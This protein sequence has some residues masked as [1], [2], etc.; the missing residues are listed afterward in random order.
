MAAAALTAFLMVLSATSCEKTG[1]KETGTDL[2]LEKT[3]V[4]AG[5]AGADFT[6]GYTMSGSHSENTVCAETQEDWIQDLKAEKSSISFTVGKNQVKE[7]RIGYIKVRISGTDKAGKIKVTQAGEPEFSITVS[8]KDM[9]SAKVSVNEATS[10]V[11]YYVSIDNKADFDSRFSTD[12]EYFEMKLA[13]I[14]V[15]A[16]VNGQT[17]SEYLTPLLKTGQSEYYDDGLYF[18]TGYYACAF[19]LSPE[20]EVL[21]SLTKV[22]FKTETFTPSE[23]CQFIIQE[24]E[25]TSSSIE[26][27]VGASDPSVRFY[28]SYMETSDFEDYSSAEEAAEDIIFTAELFDDV[29]WS[30]PSF[31]FTERTVSEFTDLSSATT[32]TVLVFGVDEYGSLTTNVTTADFTTLP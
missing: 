24:N 11:T 6:V 25:I 17:I 10:S 22:P 29:D 30:D 26:V 1:E 20:G 5:F 27:T 32:F 2:V 19:G 14:K 18:D 7:S 8:E 28:V 4:E 9:S 15:M 23:Q 31:T 16:G 13:F 3:A 21:T 12:E